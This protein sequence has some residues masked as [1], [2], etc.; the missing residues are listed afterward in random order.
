MEG[1]KRGDKT[2]GTKISKTHAERRSLIS[3]MPPFCSDF[4]ASLYAGVGAVPR[5]QG[6]SCRSTERSEAR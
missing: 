3:E 4:P 2:K 1:Q 6:C 5:C